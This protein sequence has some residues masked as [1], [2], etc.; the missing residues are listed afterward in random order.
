M[1]QYLVQLQ[2]VPLQCAGLNQ[3]HPQTIAATAVGQEVLEQWREALE[4]E[5]HTSIT[6]LEREGMAQLYLGKKK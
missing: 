2:M 4:I 6:G 5:L 3:A 1:G